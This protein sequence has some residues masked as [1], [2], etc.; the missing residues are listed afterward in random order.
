MDIRALKYF[1][2]IVEDGSLSRASRALH[3]AQPAL[4][5]Q[6]AKLEDQVGRALLVRSTKGVTPTENGL[7]LYHHARLLIRQM[8]QALMIAQAPDGAVKG[9]VTIGLPAT[10]VASIGL[11]LVQRVRARFPGILLNV[12]E[13]MS[14]HIDQMIRQRQLDLAVLFSADLSSEFA[15]SPLMVEELFV[16]VAADGDLVPPGRE[17]LTI[18]EVSR[19]PLIMPTSV[20]GLRK[21]V[22]IEF[23]SRAL[24]MNVVAEIDS[25][26][27]LM[28][29]VQEGIGATIKPMGAIMQQRGQERDWRWLR[30]SDAQMRRSNFLYSLPAE[31]LSPA[32]AIIGEEVRETVNALIRDARW[33]GFEPAP[34]ARPARPP[35]PADVRVA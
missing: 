16:I 27:L 14:G 13:A 31:H 1:V 35:R 23:E 10:T 30:I 12:V 15:V 17:T 18:E 34:G 24:S 29:C 25:L 6:V 2:Q 11:P 32:A 19:F 26:S 22:A 3:V 5:Q 28:N 33:Q 20:H 8:E 21:R 4:S 7:A 9:V